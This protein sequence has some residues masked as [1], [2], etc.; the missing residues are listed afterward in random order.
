[1]PATISEPLEVEVFYHAVRSIAEEMGAVLIR[2]ARSIN[3]RERQDASC[4]IFDARGRLVVQAE[5]HPGHLGALVS[6]VAATLRRYPQ[7]VI[8]DGDLFIGNDPYDGGG[9]HL[10][11]VT[12]AAPV[13][14]GGR[15]TAFV[16]GMG[17]WI[18]VGGK[19]PGASIEGS[20]EIYQ[21][22]LRIPPIRIR[23]AGVLDTNLLDLLLSNMRTAEENR[24]DL[25]AQIACCNIGIRGVT[26]LVERYS[27]ERFQHLCADVIRHSELKIRGA[28][29]QLP[30]TT[31]TFEDCVDDDG[32]DD[33]PVWLR[34]A[35]N[36]RHTPEPHLVF[37]LSGS[38]PQRAGGVNSVKTGV[39]AAITYALKALLD[40]TLVISAGVYDVFEVVADEGSVF[41]C[42]PP[43]PVGGKGPLLERVVE[44]C[45]GALSPILPEQVIAC[46]SSNTA[47]FFNWQDRRTGRARIHLEGIAGGM[48]ARAHL[49][50]PDAVQVHT[51]NMA[52]MPVEVCE[53]SVPVLIESFS[54]V[55]DS[56]GAGR[57]RGGLSGRKVYRVLEDL[58]FVPHGD[59][60]KFQPWGLF[61]GRPG[62]C[63]RFGF[64]RGGVE[65][66]LPSKG[67]GVSL[68]PGDLLSIQTPGGGGYGDAAER[69][70]SL[71]DH[72]LRE[73]KITAAA[74]AADYGDAH[75]A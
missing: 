44:M 11:D 72:D 42:R 71:I 6:M 69:D 55:P 3:I 24:L 38:S 25:Q 12:V 66:R 56:G 30:E 18:D 62:E 5:H 33:S 75:S 8:S 23:Q 27:S 57:Q 40:P 39:N 28:I 29:A 68:R 7:E 32:I 45:L 70:R 67:E 64:V 13:F 49:D 21:E 54:L 20:T 58:H 65:T 37:D 2:T 36:I 59:R 51:N 9:T 17:H 22:G 14:C 1:M 73:G 61:G 46:S 26:E 19:A 52:N 10:P 60:H 41:N 4:A 47:Y 34:L 35:L 50:G 53:S 16:V 31:L 15:L 74:A 63:G 43:A 48:G